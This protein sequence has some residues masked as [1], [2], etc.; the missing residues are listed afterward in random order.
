VIVL[1]VFLAAIRTTGDRTGPREPTV[2][3]SGA[4]PTE[5]V[6]LERCIDIRPTDVELLLDLGALHEQASEWDRAEDAY[7]RAIAI[8]P[9]D[10]DLRVRLAELLLRRGDTDGARREAAIARAVQPGRTAPLSVMRRADAAGV[11]R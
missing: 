7:R 8:D 3:C 10:G 6:A 11:N 5:V 4:A 9:E 1:L 2:D